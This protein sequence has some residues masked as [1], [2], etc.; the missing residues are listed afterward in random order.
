MIAPGE[1][2]GS[3]PGGIGYWAAHFTLYPNLVRV[4]LVWCG[5]VRVG[6]G[7]F[8][9]DRVGF[10]AHVVGAYGLKLATHY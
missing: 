9:S 6:E 7:W 1:G 8:S 3:V 5:S 10:A 2:F 4:G